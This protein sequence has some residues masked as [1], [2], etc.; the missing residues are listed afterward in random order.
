MDPEKEKVMLEVL[1]DAQR[2][3]TNYNKHKGDVELYRE[4][5]M[6]LGQAIAFNFEFVKESKEVSP[7]EMFDTFTNAHNDTKPLNWQNI[8]KAI[9][10][11]KR[12]YPEGVNTKP[13]RRTI[14]PNTSPENNPYVY[15]KFHPYLGNLI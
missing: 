1:K 8:Q 3:I 15:Q 13:F 12:F 10:D 14:A 9:D 2:K 7:S 11:F 5:L 4:A 6:A